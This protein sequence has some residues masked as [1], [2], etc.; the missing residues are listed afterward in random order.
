MEQR[1]ERALSERQARVLKAIVERVPPPSGKPEDPLR[2]LVFDSKYDSYRGVMTYVRIVDGTIERRMRGTLA[3]GNVRA[4][5]GFIDKAR[6]RTGSESGGT[7][8]GLAIVK[9]VVA[10]AGGT[11]EARGGRGRGLEVRCIFPTRS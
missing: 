11:V 7:G 9:H 4:K 5:T 10:S 2:A 6:S 1:G 3:E 8:L